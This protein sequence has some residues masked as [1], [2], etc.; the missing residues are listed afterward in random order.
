MST[1]P[2]SKSKSPNKPGKRPYKVDSQAALQDRNLAAIN[3]LDQQFEPTDAEPVRQ[4]AR[5]AGV[6]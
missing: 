1:Y 5:M 4:K 2:Q 3:P 6:C